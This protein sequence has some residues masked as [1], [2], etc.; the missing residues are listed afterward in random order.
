MCLHMLVFFYLKS[1]KRYVSMWRFSCRCVEVKLKLCLAFRELSHADRIT[2]RLIM[3]NTG[4]AKIN[5]AIIGLLASVALLSPGAAHAQT[6]LSKVKCSE[7]SQILQ[8]KDHEQ[9]IAG[10]LFMGY[11]WGLYKEDDESAIIGTRSD[12][13]K[14]A[15]LGQFC[16][17]NPDVDVITAAD[18]VFPTN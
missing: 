13:Q 14:L 6:D 4:R 16:Q 11:L 1:Q 10:A 18:R 7:F 2:L 5:L 9:E 8:S 12:N 3:R 17:R 15:R